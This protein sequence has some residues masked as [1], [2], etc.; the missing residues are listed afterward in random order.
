MAWAS[1]SI[2]RPFHGDEKL[3]TP[4]CFIDRDR[5][6]SRHESVRVPPRRFED[7][8]I[9]QRVESS[10]SKDRVLAQERGLARLPEPCNDDHG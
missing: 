7:S 3:R 5:F 1:L 6:V 10:A 9:V 2:D 4:L 8:E